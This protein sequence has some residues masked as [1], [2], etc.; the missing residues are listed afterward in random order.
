MLVTTS[1]KPSLLTIDVEHDWAGAGTTSIDR[2]L[3]AMLDLLA[4][5]EIS[6]TFFVVGELADQVAP[7]LEGTVHEVGSH[8]LTHRRLSQLSVADQQHE[9]VVSKRRLEAAGFRVDGFRAPFLDTTLQTSRQVAEAG[10]RY[11]ASAGQ[12]LP[13]RSPGEPLAIANMRGGIPFTMT[14]LRMLGPK[15]LRLAPTGG[16]FLCHLHEFL[17]ETEGWA[18]LPRPLRALHSRNAG[19]G[20]WQLLRS[21]LSDSQ[22]SWS[23]MTTMAA[24]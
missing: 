11:D 3:P 23:T 24:A 5:Y 6:A 21:L 8:G 19:T 1:R 12:L 16:V 22:R 15:A 17:T 7:H 10:Y 4:D 20:A 9:I 14:W 18:A 13:G 2:V